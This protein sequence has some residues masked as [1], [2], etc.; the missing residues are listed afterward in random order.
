MAKSFEETY[1]ERLWE[2][3]SY[4]ESARRKSFNLL[5]LTLASVTL[6]WIAQ[7]DSIKIPVIENRLSKFLA[8]SLAPFFIVYLVTKVLY[9]SSFSFNTFVNFI[10]T[11]EKIYCVE[12]RQYSLDS[13]EI[14]NTFRIRDI[15]ETLNVFVFPRSFEYKWKFQL[16]ILIHYITIVGHRIAT[17]L[18]ILIPFVYAT[19]TTIWFSNNFK[20][21]IKEYEGYGILTSY[22]ML[23][24]AFILIL[25]YYAERT[26]SSRLYYNSS[27]SM[28]F[29]FFKNKRLLI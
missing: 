24:I 29:K 8:L 4:L 16:K 2:S 5:I 12:M 28:D 20:N 15:S 11:F 27:I 14:Y 3:Y 23:H 9:I 6:L 13:N 17:I 26:K 10:K 7:E 22:I 21:H 18:T 19:I 25:F 1:L